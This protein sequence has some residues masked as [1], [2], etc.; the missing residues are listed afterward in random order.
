MGNAT[1]PEMKPKKGLRVSPKELFTRCDPKQ[2]HFKTT[3]ELDDLTEVLGQK[4]AAEA[5]EF[6]TGVERKGFNLFAM[7]PTGAGKYEAVRDFLER[8]AAAEATPPD[9]CY[10]HNFEETHK[11]VCLK[12]PPGTAHKFEREMEQFREDLRAAVQ[13]AFESEDYRRQRQ[14]IEEEYGEKQEQEIGKIREKAKKKDVA[15]VRTPAGLAFAPVK[16]GEVMPPDEFRDLPEKK[17]EQIES[18]ISKFQ[19]ELGKALHQRPKWQREAKARIRELSSRIIDG[20][21]AALVDELKKKYESLP[22]VQNYLNGIRDDLVEHADQFHSSRDSDH[23]QQQLAALGIP[24]PGQQAD[25]LEGIFRRYHVNVLVDHGKTKGAPVIYE[26]NPT[27]QNVVGRVEHIA[28]MGALVTDFTLIKSGALHRANGGYLILDMLKLLLHPY[29]WEGLKRSLRAGEVQTETLGQ[30]LSLITTVS[31]EPQPIPLK[32]KIVLIGERLLYYLLHRFDPDFADYFKVAVDF[33]EDIH[34]TEA[35]TRLY[36][37][38]IATLVRRERLVPFNRPA[39]ARAIEHAS[40]LAGDAEKTSVQMRGLTELLHEAD[41]W[42]RQAKRK[43]V[44]A[45]DVQQAIDKRIYRS[46]RVRERLREESEKGRI[47]IDTDGARAGQIN[48]LSVLQLGDFMF[49]NPS[50]ITAR[51]RMGTPKVID[52]EREAELGGA[53]HSKGV[54]ILSGFLSGRYLPDQPLTMLASLVF[55]QS[56]GAID[57]D[58][59]SSAELY[60]LLS[61]L[62]DAPISQALAVT[63]SVN[64]HGDVQAIGGVNEKIEGFFDIC[65][66]RGLTGR[67]GVLIPRSNKP[68][69]MLRKDVVDAARKGR[70]HIYGI[71]TIDEG[72]EILTGLRAGERQKDGEFPEGTLN[73]K[74]EDR[75]R[76]FAERA[77]AFHTADNAGARSSQ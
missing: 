57:G 44:T 2:L 58:S 48:G 21:V 15:L 63:G 33:E 64:Q 12:F 51:V 61:A 74:V 24:I 14:K 75:L 67:Q 47:L 65:R 42:A 34:R 11:P 18:T 30:M 56:Y 49:G 60:A 73:R 55:E 28:Q 35:T 27:F 31:L 4:R 77:K 29:A 53:L 10:V 40:R 71:E 70:F 76:A 23:Q 69:L 25:P 17:R 46:D 36:A 26:D 54:L 68:Q 37:R 72:I 50:R 16:N 3:D 39:V 59:A 32:V 66:Q 20:A 62:A 8:K 19:E 43:T 6:G 41:Y 22:G 38:W 52:I 7:G 5:L 9:W 13:S 1:K 45:A